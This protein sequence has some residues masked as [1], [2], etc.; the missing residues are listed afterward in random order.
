MKKILPIII[1]CGTGL[2]V[3]AGYFFKIELAPVL[4]L[5]IH[6]GISLVG[7]AGLIGIAYL[8][9]M[10]FIRIARR[11]KGGFYSVI[12]L[13][14]FLFTFIA[15]LILTPDNPLYRDWVLNIQ[16]P[17]EASLLA[18]LS[19]TLLYASLYLIRTRGWTPMSVGFL[20]GALV[21]LILNL[22]VLQFQPGSMGE[23]WALF[24][25]RLPL[26]GLRGILIGMALGGLIVGLR[27]LLAVDRP[28]E[29]E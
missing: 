14:A 17:V 13:I 7:L 4:G 24:L 12:V 5:L 22:A 26:A 16:V 20:V 1:A 8:V 11:Q 2:T 28:Y 29:G 15:G 27:V 18:I 3:L 21:S 23:V 9:R 6:W 25:R 19:V 10:H